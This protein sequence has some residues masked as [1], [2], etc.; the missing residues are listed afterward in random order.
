VALTARDI[1]EIEKAHPEGLSSRQILEVLE[2]HGEPLSE[3]T[4]RKY[5][6]LGL[7]P[8]SRRVG[9][10]GKHRG[11]RGI[12][13]V[14]VVRRVDEIRRAMSE[15]E[16]LESL[17]R[18]GL[19]FRAKLSTL[20]TAVEEALGAAEAD[21]AAGE[22]ALERGQRGS[23]KSELGE[24]RRDAKGWLRA[25][26]RVAGELEQ[27]LRTANRAAGARLD[28]VEPPLKLAK[29]SGWSQGVARSNKRAVGARAVGA[30]RRGGV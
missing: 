17:A 19:A 30:R 28:G 9:Q 4:L 5:V 10:K 14:E 18:N 22:Q 7:L 8:R 20:R 13:P 11:S 12:Y 24:L 6:Q 29:S 26:E 23:L 16:T 25:L 15:G 27:A 3:A 1:Q 21:L 2:R